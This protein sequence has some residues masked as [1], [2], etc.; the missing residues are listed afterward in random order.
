MADTKTTDIYQ[1][2]DFEDWYQHHYKTAYDGNTGW[3]QGK[4]SDYD[5]QVGQK[6]YNSYNKKQYYQQEH[7]K[8][9]EASA[10]RATSAK[11]SADVSR[12]RLEKYLPQQLAL[13]G[14]HG[15]GMSEDAYL[16]LQSQYQGA[17]SEANAQH[18]ANLADY[19][20]AYDAQKF[21]LDTQTSDAVQG[22]IDQKKV[23]DANLV[24]EQERSFNEAYAGLNSMTFATE[25]DVD[26]YLK[27]F[28]G[29]VS[30][31]QMIQLENAAAGIK[32]DIA[33]L[34]EQSRAR[35]YNE[36]SFGGDITK[37]ENIDLML[38][39]TSYRIEADGVAGEIE[40]FP[41]NIKDGEIFKCDGKVY[42]KYGNY[43]YATRPY[44]D[45]KEEGAKYA[46]LENVLKE[47]KKSETT[48]MIDQS[49]L[50]ESQESFI[51]KDRLKVK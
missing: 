10:Q 38:G 6:L 13:Q 3:T 23:D 51:N 37:G 19:K 39:N 45:N 28:K 33:E 40:D 50:K 11:I 42:F 34:K 21:T 31:T 2:K 1:A 27:N 48:G 8:A 22:I 18:E 44:H 41:S 17:V 36:R 4:M 43:V 29:K 35:V 26:T 49:G 5:W 9:A 25:G 7:D 47:Y 15:T 32:A 16:K 20:S 30:E 24:I 46:Q 12:Q 14:L